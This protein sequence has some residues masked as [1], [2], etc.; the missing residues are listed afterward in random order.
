MGL[1]AI[2]MIRRVVCL[3]PLMVWSITPLVWSIIFGLTSRPPGD[4]RWPGP[5]FFFWE[6]S[7]AEFVKAAK[8]PEI[9]QECLLRNRIQAHIT[10][11]NHEFHF[12]FQAL[13]PDHTLFP[14]RKQHESAQNRRPPDPDVGVWLDYALKL[15]KNLMDLHLQNLTWNL[16]MMVFNR[17]LLFQG[18]I[19]RF[20]VNLQ[21]RTGFMYIDLTPIVGNKIPGNCLWEVL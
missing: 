21:G 3:T 9:L 11:S 12:G 20:H 16:K 14:L 7:A 4:F 10:N 13:W 1:L 18:L 5:G 19:F 8:L 17:N 6:I 15:F 2:P